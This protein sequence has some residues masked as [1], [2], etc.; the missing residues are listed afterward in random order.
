[1]AEKA[2]KKII[3][4]LKSADDNDKLAALA[5][6]IKLF[7]SPEAL[8]KSNC[9]NE[10]WEALRSSQFLERAL[11][12]S[13][14]QP[15][16]ISILSV[17]V[18]IGKPSDFH[19]FLKPISSMLQMDNCEYL[20]I[21]ISQKLED[22]S[23]IFQYIH[24]SVSTLRLLTLCTT[25]SRKCTITPSLIDAREKIFELIST[26]N[27]INN[28]KYLFMLISNLTK[29]TKYQF[30]VFKRPPQIDFSL[31]L[32]SEK[33]AMIELRLQ[34]DTPLNY[35][36]IEVKER[37]ERE[38]EEKELADQ[39]N[40]EKETDYEI[41]DENLETDE[42]DQTDIDKYQEKNE[43]NE[44][45]KPIPMKF[46]QNIGSIIDDEL[47]SASCQLLELL[48]KPLVEYE[49]SFTD[50]DIDSYF[51]TINSLIHDS[52]EIF[53]AANSVRDCNRK[54]LKCLLSIVALWLRDGEFLCA[55]KDLINTFPHLF[56]LLK[57]FHE[58]AMQF[59][60]A[61][62][63]WSDDYLKKLKISGF[64]DLAAVLL[65]I[66]Q[67]EDKAAINLILSKMNKL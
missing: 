46:T 42:Q 53:K 34:L 51:N 40:R 65:P 26:D 35:K 58:E 14:A 54:E 4:N 20:F 66:A 67:S 7:P 15:L 63:F 19:T 11:K 10:I 18:H 36:E 33:L 50:Q 32:A 44:K 28:R 5:Y 61:F 57:S 38:K 43:E 59:L 3:K 52:C 16:V 49:E 12:M 39:R 13:E 25:N 64:Q 31:F 6:L 56:Q 24:V 9:A 55:N 8:L 29:A 23:P 48:V 60:P 27:D 30:A 2:I 62:T 45:I 17:F 21:S 41:I 22:I 1:M 47:A 37:N